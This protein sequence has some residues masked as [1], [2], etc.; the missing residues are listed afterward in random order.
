M[1]LDIGTTLL[2]TIFFK[3]AFAG[4]FWIMQLVIILATLIIITRKFSDWK[5]LALPVMIGWM[6]FGMKMNWMFYA[7]AT[8]MFVMS[9]VSTKMIEGAIGS[10]SQSIS[11][12]IDYGGLKKI[13][14]NRN[15][16]VNKRKLDIRTEMEKLQG[17]DNLRKIKSNLEMSKQLK[18][19]ESKKLEKNKRKQARERIEMNALE[20]EHLKRAYPTTWQELVR[21]DRMKKDGLVRDKKEDYY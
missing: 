20:L 3:T 8:I 6:Y 21:I 7:I 4:Q 2:E 14:E 17:E 12:I 15:L 18:E 1:G 10:V 19:Y 16:K 13:R 5:E 9:T 11:N